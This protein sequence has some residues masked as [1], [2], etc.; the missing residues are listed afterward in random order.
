[1]AS[2]HEHEVEVVV[3]GIVSSLQLPVALI[4]KMMSRW[5]MI[6]LL[7]PEEDLASPRTS[8]T[9]LYLWESHPRL[10]RRPLALSRHAG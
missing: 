5:R 10:C 6:L 9:L 8:A 2:T 3:V 7:V 4:Q 1:M